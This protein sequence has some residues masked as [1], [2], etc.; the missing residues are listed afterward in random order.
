MQASDGGEVEAKVSATADSG[1]SGCRQGGE[2]VTGVRGAKA[3]E[4]SVFGRWEP[5]NTVRLP[6]ALGPGGGQCCGS[7]TD[8]P[9]TKSVGQ[10]KWVVASVRS[11]TSTPYDAPREGVRRV[12]AAGRFL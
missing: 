11:C 10:S 7:P 5:Y 1:E 3:W 8:D 9:H 12:T 4:R 6:E 2:I